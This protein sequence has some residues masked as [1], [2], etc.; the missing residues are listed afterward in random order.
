MAS[1][2]QVLGQL[3]SQVCGI[4]LYDVQTT[5]IRLG[6]RLVL[7][8]EPTNAYDVN[9]VAVLALSPSPRRMLGHLAKESARRVAPLLLA[10]LV[11]TG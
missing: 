5:R 2:H 3:T 8:H 4:K 10:G 11:V 6:E 1:K 7:R 9:A